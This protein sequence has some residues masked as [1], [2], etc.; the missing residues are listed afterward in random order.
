MNSQLVDTLKATA[1][2][3]EP[4]D[5]EIVNEWYNYGLSIGDDFFMKFMMHWIG[6]NWVY[7]SYE[8][9]NEGHPSEIV[10]ICSCVSENIDTFK[11]Y[12][13]FN[14]EEI[15]IFLEKAIVDGRTGKRYE[16]FWK[17]LSE[18]KNEDER[19]LAL[20]KTLYKVR[21][22]L[23]HGSKSIHNPRDIKL[24]KASSVILEG[25]LKVFLDEHK[26]MRG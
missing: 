23:F 15:Q 5:R 25:Y 14:S 26:D 18:N 2:S 3:S 4:W 1:T 17:Q 9:K 7:S 10:A 13:A 11:K 6:F 16:K 20:F 21:C 22:N 19:I 12:D 24:V 8:N